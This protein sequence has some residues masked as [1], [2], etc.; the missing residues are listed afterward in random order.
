[1]TKKDYEL[2]AGCIKRVAA[3]WKPESKY[4]V[5]VNDLYTELSEAL[6]ANNSKF[7]RV[8]FLQACQVN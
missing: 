7:D 2:I 3:K 1:M 5:V 4:A 8:K 6:A